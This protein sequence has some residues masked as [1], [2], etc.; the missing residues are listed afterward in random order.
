MP[1]PSARPRAAS[2][3]GRKARRFARRRKPSRRRRL[4]RRPLRLDASPQSP[5]RA[6]AAAARE[7][8][9]PRQAPAPRRAQRRQATEIQ[10]A[11]APPEP[12][13]SAAPAP[14]LAKTDKP[15]AAALAPAAPPASSSDAVR[16]G[17]PI[18]GAGRGGARPQHRAGDRAGREGDGRLPAP[19]RERRDQDDDRRRN[20]RDGQVDRP[21][22]RILPLRSAAGAR[23][24][25]GLGDA[26]RQSLGLDAAAAARRAGGAGRRARPLRQALRRR[27][28]AQQSVLRF[29]QAGL[30]ADDALGGRSGQAGRRTRSPRT[31]QGAILS[32]PGHGRA[33]ALQLRGHQ[34]GTCCARRWPRAARTSCGASRCWPKTSR[35]ATATCAFASPTRARSSSASTSRRRPAR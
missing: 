7:T 33:V 18:S 28:V 12:A 29:H 26:V 9:A 23:G 27:R 5:C 1:R 24:A 8:P 30:R 14:P 6:T 4:R 19:A 15:P 32:A 10:T 17:R 34:S 3:R 21:G 35:R 31:R 13:Q 11:P 16:R 2:R 20:R 25:N 22:R